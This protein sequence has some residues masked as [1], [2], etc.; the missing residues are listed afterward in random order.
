MCILSYRQ[1]EE[2]S[3]C[4]VEKTG[5]CTGNFNSTMTSSLNGIEKCR[6]TTSSQNTAAV[7]ETLQ[8]CS[9][10]PYECNATKARDCLAKYINQETDL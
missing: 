7:E 9:E 2:A 1:L 10:I 3:A 8:V 5:G 4:F 6:Y